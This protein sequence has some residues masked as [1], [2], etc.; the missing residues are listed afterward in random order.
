MIENRAG[1]QVKKNYYENN[2]RAFRFVWWTCVAY[3]FSGGLSG[4]ALKALI[5]GVNYSFVFYLPSIIAGSIVGVIV[6]SGVA[7]VVRNISFRKLNNV[8][9]L[10]A[11]MGVTD[12]KE[13]LSNEDEFYTKLVQINFKYID[14]Y[15]LQ[16][17]E[18]ADKSFRLSAFASIAGLLVIVVGIYMMYNITGRSSLPS[19]VATGS[20]VLIEF[21][22]AVFFYLYSKTV[23]KM[24]QYHKKLLVTQNINLALK[25]VDKLEDGVKGEAL[26]SLVDRLT[27]DINQYLSEE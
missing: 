15:Y 16:T 22:S 10:L 27:G 21:I 25:V 23:Q 8:E 9:N 5:G 7:F 19:Y 1:L 26:K 3:L 13:D 11:Q 2:L 24:S 4:Y 20:G 12:P 6:Y 18:Q 17:Q 14:Q